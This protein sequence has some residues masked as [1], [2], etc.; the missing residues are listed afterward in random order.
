MLTKSKNKSI[1]YQPSYILYSGSKIL[2]SLNNKFP[3]VVKKISV[4]SFDYDLFFKQDKSLNFNIKKKF[5]VYIDEANS[6]HPDLLNSDVEKNCD[7]E[8]FNKEILNFFDYFEKKTDIEIVIA[9]HP[10]VNYDG[11]K[12][13]FG[14]RKI[15]FNLT[16]ESIKKSNVVIAHASASISFAILANKPLIFLN[17]RN[18]VSSYQYLIESF[19]LTLN[20]K[21][22]DISRNRYKL[23]NFKIDYYAYENYRNDYLKE[24]KIKNQNPWITLCN[25]LLG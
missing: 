22:I 16:K 15:F 9:A 19:A 25:V 13:I 18:F 7:E 1:K 6:F 10:K 5:A 21:S 20:N 3:A 23:G 24:N 8:I 17:S 12:K 4:P 11:K 2:N 14:N